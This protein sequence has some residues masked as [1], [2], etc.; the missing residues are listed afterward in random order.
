MS[1]QASTSQG[2]TSQE[3][4]L[5]QENSDLHQGSDTQSTGSEISESSHLTRMSST[6]KTEVPTESLD[7]PGEQID[8]LGMMPWEEERESCL[9]RIV[10][11]CKEIKKLK[12]EIKCTSEC[13]TPLPKSFPVVWK[14]CRKALKDNLQIEDKCEELNVLMKI[15]IELKVALEK[16]VQHLEEIQTN[17]KRLQA[18]R[19]EILLAHAEWTVTPKP[20]LW[21][22]FILS[23][24]RK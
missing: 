4:N 15:N 17:H 1:S 10:L 20:S 2:Q 14:E 8:T 13:K 19:S 23:F 5:L 24:K 22:R 12:L 6:E 16:Q 21:R 3:E 7:D 9:Q 11:L 18:Q